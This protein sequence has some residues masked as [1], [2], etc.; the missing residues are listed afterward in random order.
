MY[1]C[2]YG[3]SEV[4][5]EARRQADTEERG[6]GITEEMSG[7]KNDVY[8]LS[9]D[10]RIASKTDGRRYGDSEVRSEAR[11]QDDTEEP[12]YG[13]IE[14]HSEMTALPDACIASKD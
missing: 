2:R 7:I 5:S 11:R 1:G 4:R 6:H 3:E 8:I 14:I 10:S 9:K 12:R 13:I